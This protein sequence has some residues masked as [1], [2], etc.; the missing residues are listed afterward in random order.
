M[1]SYLK[2]I[3]NPQDDISLRRIIN[4]PKRSI[5]DATVK[6]V[7]DYSDEFELDLWEALIEVRTIATLTPRN[8]SCIDKFTAIINKYINS[9]SNMLPSKIIE[10]LLEDTGY[11]KWL[12]KSGEIEDKSRIENLKELVSDAV[13]FEKNSEDKSLEAYLEKVSLVQDTDKLNE[14]KEIGRAHV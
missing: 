7:Q 1:L 11:I 12:E 13:D 4:V 10:G 9:K 6:K 8:A 2:A 3:V 14:E 5:G